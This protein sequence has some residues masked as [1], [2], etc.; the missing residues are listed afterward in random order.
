M[1]QI[2]KKVA[3]KGALQ[4]SS[5]GLNNVEYNEVSLSGGAVSTTIP[6]NTQTIVMQ[7]RTVS[8]AVEAFIEH[9]G[10]ETLIDRWGSSAI[11]SNQPRVFPVSSLT[12]SGGYPKLKLTGDT[13]QTVHLWFY[14]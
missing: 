3:P 2:Y 13:S 10:G 14:K 5:T 7:T 1:N 6:D 9:S 12:S 4:L 8:Q 11:G